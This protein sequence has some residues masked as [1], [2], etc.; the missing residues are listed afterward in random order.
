MKIL[1]T[2][3]SLLPLNGISQFWCYPYALRWPT[4]T[5][6]H[7]WVCGVLAACLACHH[8]TRT[9]FRRGRSESWLSPSRSLSSTPVLALLRSPNDHA[10][11]SRRISRGERVQ[12]LSTPPPTKLPILRLHFSVGHCG[13]DMYTDHL[14]SIFQCSESRHGPPEYLECCVHLDEYTET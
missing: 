1:H 10:R 14:E 13:S 4:V 7:R 9:R 12:E 2:Y 8:E 11:L 5:S 3:A 6:W